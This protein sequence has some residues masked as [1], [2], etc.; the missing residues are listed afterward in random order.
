MGGLT[1]ILSAIGCDDH[2]ESNLKLNGDT[3]II[4]LALD[5]YAG[6][7]DKKALTVTVGVP[8]SYDTEEMRVTELQLSEGAVSNVVQGDVL[9]GS[10]SHAIQ[11]TNG[12]VYQNYTLIVKHDE[13]RILSFKLN[14][15]YTGLIDQE[16]HTITVRVPSTADVTSMVPIIQTSAG[17]VVM[18][19]SGQVQDF[20]HP[21]QFT[22][23]YQ[24][25]TAVYTVTVIP[26]DAPSAVY[27]GLPATLDELN[28]EEKAAAIWMMA[29]VAN[30]QYVSFDDICYNRV[31]L[32]ECQIIW[33]HLHIEGGI[34]NMDKFAQHAPQ[35]INAAV[36][37][38]ELYDRG[39]HFLLTRYATYYAVQLGAAKDDMFPNNCWGGTEENGEITSGPWSF[40]NKNHETHP[41]YRNLFMKEGEPSAVF[42][43]DAGYRT[44]NSTAQW[45]IGT[46]WGGYADVATWRQK[47]GGVDLGH[48][49]DGAIVLWEYPA[50]DGKG[51]I[52]CIGSGCY[53]WYSFGVDI[54]ADRF[55][56]N[57]ATM[58]E[59]A[60]N[61][62]I[63]Q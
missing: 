33:W 50:S 2:H 9:N 34:D 57:V 22:V 23:S 28:P 62:L 41:V 63:N 45:H 36:K 48:G 6:V 11:V 43:F 19:A 17:A 39:V 1:V 5:D 58:T 55:H 60:I 31:D 42:T 49:G 54:S 27:I 59:N 30:A 26:T 29:H 21:V 3:H 4:A 12:D 37:M 61:Y 44:T 24:S 38:K 18:P 52:V 56:G 35:A 10:F 53:D 14:D 8:E 40:S 13:A 32:S 15:A 16:Q 46:D 20:T 51:G 7:I 47:H 25:A